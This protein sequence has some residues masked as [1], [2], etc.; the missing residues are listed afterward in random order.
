MFT[1]ALPIYKTHFELF[2]TDNVGLCSGAY[3]CA[4]VGV[5]VFEAIGL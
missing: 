1:L 2:E 3:G 4:V 5:D